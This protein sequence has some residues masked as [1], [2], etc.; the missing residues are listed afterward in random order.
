MIFSISLEN[1][2][3]LGIGYFIPFVKEIVSEKDF[4]D[5]VI[6]FAKAE[7]FKGKRIASSWRSEEH[8]SE[9]QSH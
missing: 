4:K 7:G 1:S 3:N 8:T 2:N 6:D 5:E 9:L